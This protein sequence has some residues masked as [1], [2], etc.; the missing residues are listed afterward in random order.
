MKAKPIRLHLVGFGTVG[1]GLVR[2]LKEQGPALRRA[3]LDFRIAALSDIWGTLHAPKGLDPARLLR[4]PRPSEAKGRAPAGAKRMS[5]AEAARKLDSDILVEMTPTNVVTGQPALG[6]LEAALGAGR[7]AVTSNKGPLAMRYR[8]L[9][10]LAAKNGAELRYEAA[11]GGAMPIINLAREALAGNPVLSIRGVLNG[12]TNYILTRMAEDSLPFAEALAEAQ[13][14]GYAEAD[15]SYDIEGKDAGA[16]LVI[17]A[18]AIFGRNARYSQVR[19]TGITGITPEALQLADRAGCALRLVAQ[20]DRN[21][22]MEVAPRL[23]RRNS[24]LAVEGTL[25]A[26][27]LITELAGEITVTGRGA[28]ALEA[29]SAILSDLVSLGSRRAFPGKG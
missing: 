5:G 3:G 14:L 28:G 18:N 11:V 6:H 20:A 27:S 12:T 9:M 10:A 17:L 22:P 24:A 8:E 21:G 29:A 15:P 2:V 1:R 13:E 4:I 16:K 26:A 7:C 23:V 25:N 19:V